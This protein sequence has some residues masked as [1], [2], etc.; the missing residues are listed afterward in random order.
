MKSCLLLMPR[1]GSEQIIGEDVGRAGVGVYDCE[2][3]TT[4]TV[5]VLSSRFGAELVVCVRLYRNE[6]R[7]S[8]IGDVSSV[9]AY[10]KGS[11]SAIKLIRVDGPLSVRFRFVPPVK[12][13]V[14]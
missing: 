12:S 2:A 6:L 5:D 11:C 10:R 8:S 9:E 14:Q 3:R 13:A 7:D 1:I 4:G